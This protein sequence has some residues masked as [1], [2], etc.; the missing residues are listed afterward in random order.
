MDVLSAV[1]ITE[2]LLYGPVTKQRLLLIRLT[3]STVADSSK[4]INTEQL[5]KLQILC[6]QME[7]LMDIQKFVDEED[8]VC[9]MKFLYWHQSMITIYLKQLYSQNQD[10]QR[11]KV[12]DC[13]NLYGWSF[14]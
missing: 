5:T 6:N 7:N 2:D 10:V 9:S 13:M 11:V 14:E 4:L 1:N 3:L 8:G 12:I